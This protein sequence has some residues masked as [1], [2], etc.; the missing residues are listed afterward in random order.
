MKDLSVGVPYLISGKLYTLR[1]Q[2]HKRLII[3]KNENKVPI[4]LSNSTIYYCGP[5]PTKEGEIIGSC[6]P[7][8]SARMDKYVNDL[9]EL[10]Q[11]IM[12]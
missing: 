12:I 10:G 1:D 6:G 7:T 4:D 5:T 9:A 8:T 2:A 11:A 3:D